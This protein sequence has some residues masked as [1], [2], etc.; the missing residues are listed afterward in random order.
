MSTSFMI[1]EHKVHS[2]EIVESGSNFDVIYSSLEEYHSLTK[3][4]TPQEVIAGACKMLVAAAYHL[5]D[6]E[7]DEEFCKGFNDYRPGAEFPALYHS[8][9]DEV[10]RRKS[11]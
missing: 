5:S 8:L 3:Q 1:F 11:K 2:L 4:F 9:L 6:E 10:V 7:F